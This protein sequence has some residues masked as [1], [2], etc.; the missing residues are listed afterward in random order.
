MENKDFF[1]YKGRPL[2]RKGD[3]MY[4]GEVYEDFVA[5]IQ[6]ESYYDL[7]DIKIGNKIFLHLISTDPNVGP[8]DVVVKHTI[9]NSLYEALDIAGI[10]IDRYTKRAAV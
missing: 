1:R 8:Q 7:K 5:M 3:L 2:V 4:Y 10:W 9:K 6:V